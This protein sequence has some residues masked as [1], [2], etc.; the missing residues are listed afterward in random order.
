MKRKHKYPTD[1][2]AG[3]RTITQIRA[4]PAGQLSDSE[5]VKCFF[6]RFKATALILTYM[7]D[8]GTYCLGRLKRG[9]NPMAYYR[10]LSRQLQKAFEG[11]EIKEQEA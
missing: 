8:S 1:T 5:F 3:I 2:E 7:D 10:G 4:T 9:A 11:A 6:D